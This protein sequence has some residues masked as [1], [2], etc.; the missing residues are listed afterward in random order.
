MQWCS[1]Q[2]PILAGHCMQV[3]DKH[4]RIDVLV[5]NAAEQHCIPDVTDTDPAVLERTFQINVFSM[6]YLCKY[7]VP[8]MPRGSAIVN[9]TSVVAYY[10]SGSLLEYSATKGAIVAFTR[11]LANQLATKGIRVNAVAP[12]PVRW[13][14]PVEDLV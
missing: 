13:F 2:S 3:I 10:G 8:H 1:A 9:S 5:N 12:G 6:F 7:A 11:A 4:G 14:L